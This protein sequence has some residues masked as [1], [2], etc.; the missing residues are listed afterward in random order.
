M[1]EAH[2]VGP[3][4]LARRDAPSVLAVAPCEA[5]AEGVPAAQGTGRRWL[6]RGWKGGIAPSRAALQPLNGALPR[7]RHADR[8]SVATARAGGGG[9]RAASRSDGRGAWQGGRTAAIPHSASVYLG[10]EGMMGGEAQDRIA[11]FQPRFGGS[12]TGRPTTWRRYSGSWPDSTSAGATTP[13]PAR[14][15]LFSEAH[16]TLVWEHLASWTGPLPSQLRGMRRG[17]LREVGFALGG[18]ARGAG[19]RSCVPGLPARGA[20]GRSRARRPPAATEEP[21]SPARCWRRYAPA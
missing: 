10:P 8:V 2:P 1:A 17:L 5:G 20:Q 18:G 21:P 12:R 9:A 14:R 4:A 15:A 13:H 3:A 11:G 6:G 7:A 16:L 19:A